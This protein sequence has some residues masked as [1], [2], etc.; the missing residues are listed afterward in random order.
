MGDIERAD[1]TPPTPQAELRPRAPSPE[2]SAPAY[3][4]PPLF[5]QVSLTGLARF[6]FPFLPPDGE[7]R[8]PRVAYRRS[9]LWLRHG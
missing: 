9:A 5:T 3:P 2:P 8:P 7:G 4:P 1:T 6:R